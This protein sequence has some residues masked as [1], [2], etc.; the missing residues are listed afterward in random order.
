MLVKGVDSKWNKQLA[1]RKNYLWKKKELG[2][3]GTKYRIQTNDFKK[4]FDI[5]YGNK[6]RKFRDVGISY[7]INPN[8]GEREMFVA[9]TGNWLDWVFNVTNAVT[10][11]T[12]KVIGPLLDNTWRINTRH[13]NFLQRRPKLYDLHIDRKSQQRGIA[14]LAR[15][16]GVDVM[17]GHSRGG[18]LVSDASFSGKKYG[19]DAAMLLAENTD[20]TNYRRPGLIDWSLGI[21]GKRNQIVT[22]GHGIHWAYGP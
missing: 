5:A 6:G 3:Q 22:S 19:L 12:E 4:G 18:A 10:Y 1:Q 14:R 20:V 15:K 8:T 7:A 2:F 13:Y 21:S 11:G 16:H 9:G 17:Y